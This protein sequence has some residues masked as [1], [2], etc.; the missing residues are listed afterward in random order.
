M[1]DEKN[2][3]LEEKISRPRLGAGSNSGLSSGSNSW[4]SSWFSSRFNSGQGAWFSWQLLIS[5]TLVL[6]GLSAIGGG[7]YLMITTTNTVCIS[8]EIAP[9]ASGSAMVSPAKAQLYVDLAGAVN[10]P[11][12]YELEVGSRL[13]AA[14]NKAGGFAKQADPAFVSQELNLAQ[15]LQ[16]GEKI[17]IFSQKERQ[18]LEEAEEFCS[19]QSSLLSA[20]AKQA[21][22]TQ[23]SELKTQLSINTASA[24]EL[25][26]LEGIGEKRASDIIA[27]RPYQQVTDLVEKKVLTETIF[28]NIQNQLKL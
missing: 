14:I 20:S 23:E 25:Q 5:S 19:Q 1:F 9:V 12:L 2:F 28:K 16:D 8:E 17:Y 21:Q 27:N 11:G 10:Q 22:Q 13:A 7:L 24:K 3:L 26:T 6:I 4:L 18:Y 15:K